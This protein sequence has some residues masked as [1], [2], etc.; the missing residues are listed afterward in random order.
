ML[1]RAAGFEPAVPS[2]ARLTAVWI[3][4]F[5]YARMNWWSTPESNRPGSDLAR[6]A[7]GPSAC[8]EFGGPCRTWPDCFDGP[9][10][11]GVGFEPTS[12]ALQAGAFTRLAFRAIQ[13]ISRKRGHRFSERECD[14]A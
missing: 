1:A 6:I 7:R 3:S 11:P 14:K 12:P 4:Q 2:G 8:P 10:V 13:S 9:L 5:S